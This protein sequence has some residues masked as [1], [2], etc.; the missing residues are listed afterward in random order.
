MEYLSFTK[1]QIEEVGKKVLELH[2]QKY[3]CSES[4]I[5]AVWPYVL[6]ESE[7]TSRILKIAMPFRGGI[8]ASM[9]SH[10]GG[11]T[12]GFMLIGA[13]YGRD[14]IDGDGRLAPALCRQYWKM[15]LDEFGTS[16]CTLLRQGEPG[17]EAPSRCGC[18]MV[19]SAQ[20]M[21]KFFNKIHEENQPIEDI[22]S[23]KLD[24]SHEPCHEQV[25]PIKSSD[26]K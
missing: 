15:F 21:L 14:D 12:I 5:R 17:P 2:L 10:C 13:I 25:V 16:N 19:R 11:L 8:G 3:H 7:L 26:E 20:L 18:I 24:R 23:F 22:Y 9:S 6:P 1:Y 4:L